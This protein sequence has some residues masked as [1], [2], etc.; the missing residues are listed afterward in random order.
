[1]IFVASTGGALEVFDFAVYGFF[2]QSIGREFFPARM[3]VPAETLSFAVL[4]A[5]SMSRLVGGI[6]LGRLGD[7]YGRRIVFASSA[8]VA[9][10]STLLIAILPSYESLGVA[11]PMLLVL[12]RI[13]QGLCLGGE[14]PGAVIY[15]V[16]TAHA[17]PGILCGMVFLAVNIALMLA[18]SINLGVQMI[19]TSDQVRAFGWRIGFLVGGLLGLL[20]FVVRRTLAETDEYAR[21]VSARHREP[22]AVL[23]RKHAASVLTGV[24]AASLVGASSGLFVAHMPAYLQTLHYDPRKIASAQT[25][26]VTAISGCILVTAYLGDLLSRRYVFMSGAVLSALFAPFFY[27]AVTRHQ[28][29]LPLLF[30][31]AGV[32]ASF[33]NGTYACAIAEMFPVD[34]RFSG[35]A[36]TMN[37]GLA[38]PMAIAPLAASILASTTNWA[39]SPALVMV[40]C[41]TFAFVA[42]FRMKR[43]RQEA[44]GVKMGN[45]SLLQ[46]RK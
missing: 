18:I 2:A 28:A 35:L 23:F 39:F 17:K 7:K 30:L 44:I 41:A 15:A 9:A 12:L 31:M 37:V 34:V 26:Y 42:S 27:V 20:S 25:L 4:A 32:V 11:A 10:V 45:E 6:F 3:G 33:A 16:E 46:E 40:L 43:H 8:M 19:F 13:T 24:A 1:M 14:L 21:R 29:S 38:A 22:L 5:G 36:T